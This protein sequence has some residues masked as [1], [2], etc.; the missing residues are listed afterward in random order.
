M[1]PSL[2]D[3][4]LLLV[5][6]LCDLHTLRA[7]C[8]SHRMDGT[9]EEGF[10]Y[11]LASRHGLHIRRTSRSLRSRAN[12]RQTFFASLATQAARRAVQVERATL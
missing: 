10:W 5:L 4:L 3:D 12:L 7:V 9:R 6:E 8:C 11:S 1:L 2:T